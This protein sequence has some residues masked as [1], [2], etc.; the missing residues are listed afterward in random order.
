MQQVE[1]RHV[2]VDVTGRWA[3]GEHPGILVG[4]RQV[5]VSGRR[6]WQGWVIHAAGDR[7]S[8]SVSQS[9]VDARLIRPVD[10]VR[11]RADLSGYHP[12]NA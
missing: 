10:A 3:G 12:V 8:S 11:P 2:W 7:E 9:W 4:W 5:N 6:E 1:P